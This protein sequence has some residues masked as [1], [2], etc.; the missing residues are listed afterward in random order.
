MTGN[1][2]LCRPRPIEVFHRRGRIGLYVF[3]HDLGQSRCYRAVCHS[4]SGNRRIRSIFER[5]LRLPVK[6]AIIKEIY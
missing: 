6:Y 4:R 3:L 1:A 5:N 2:P